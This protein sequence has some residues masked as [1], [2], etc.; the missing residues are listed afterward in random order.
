MKNRFF[1]SLVYLTIC[2][3]AYSLIPPPTAAAAGEFTADYDVSYAITPAGVAIVTQNIT[4]TNRQ[5]NLYPQKYTITIDSDTVRNVVASD[6]GG[7]ISPTVEKK[8]A[9][10]EITV[11]F[12][13]PAIGIGK[14]TTFTLRY[15]NSDV[16][17]QIGNIWE[18]AI[19]AV[20]DDPDMNSYTVSL[21]TPSNFGPLAYVSPSPAN[22]AQWSR[23][24]M[25]AGGISAAYGKEQ[26]ARLSL[27]YYLENPRQESAVEKIVLPP[28]TGYQ[29]VTFDRI[30]PK[31]E[32]MV[33]DEEGNWIGRYTL[34]PREKMVINATVSV[35]ISSSPTNAMAPLTADRRTAYLAP[36]PY[37]QS[38][39]PQ[40]ASRAGELKSA[41]AIYE[42]VVN[43]LSYD[44]DR[45]EAAPLRKGAVGALATPASSLCLEF[46]DLFIAIARAAGIPARQAIGYAHSTNKT[47]RPLSL[48][49]DVLH[50]WPEYY[51]NETGVW[52]AVDPTWGRTTGGIDYFS[53]MDF[54]HIVFA[55]RGH[56]SEDPLPVGFYRDGA[57]NGKN[58]SV[59]FL[60]SGEPMPSGSIA[61][62]F[63]FPEVVTAGFTAHGE[64]IV[65]NRGGTEVKALPVDIIARPLAFRTRHVIE[66]IAPYTAYRLSITIPVALRT[67]RAGGTLTATVNG[68]SI[69]HTFDVQPIGWLYIALFGMIASAGLL[70]WIAVTRPFSQK[71]R[72]T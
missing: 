2:L 11:P 4:L 3:F 58:I 68:A 54:S 26:F 1:P 53:K 8:D 59:T 49:S 44:Y 30:E 47:L 46:T 45:I 66:A 33:R 36:Q 43:A 12:N 34:K 71:T 62:R 7:V 9:K 56:S 65:E 63:N 64:L 60:S 18:L 69:I 28:D 22:G 20:Q 37:W 27:R 24:Q 39:D 23:D 40:I 50:S 16:M 57:S 41:E 51:D 13:K 31:P 67:T 25:V 72:K 10:T 35:V 38:N 19:P 70:L 17:K 32:E 29:R 21:Q 48:V 42:Y 55:L 61:V 6:Q 5:S 52:I 14:K 15:E